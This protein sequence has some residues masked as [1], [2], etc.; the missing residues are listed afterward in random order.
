ML[1]VRRKNSAA[2]QKIRLAS[3]NDPLKR[4]GIVLFV[5]KGT[6]LA[7]VPP[8]RGSDDPR[9]V[10]PRQTTATASIVSLARVR[11]ILRPA[12]MPLPR[13]GTRRA[14]SGTGSPSWLDPAGKPT[15][16][17]GPHLMFLQPH[18]PLLPLLAQTLR[19][20][21]VTFDSGISHGRS[22]LTVRSPPP[23]LRPRQSERSFSHPS[24]L[25]KEH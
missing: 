17:A 18:P 24:T 25:L 15:R 14:T 7:V 9:R 6:S 21:Y 3:G 5:S 20:L 23:T 2:L 19:L 22:S 8:S 11:L 1:D 4:S 13:W 10:A 12:H 16:C